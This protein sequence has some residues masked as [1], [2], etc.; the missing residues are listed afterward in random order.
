VEDSRA[1][2]QLN[3]L[4]QLDAE[5]ELQSCCAS[6]AWASRVAAARPFSDIDG[7]ISTSEAT[8]AGLDW[9]EIEAALS[10][11]PRIGQRAAGA[12]REASW[13]AQEQAS[14]AAAPVETS[15]ALREVNEAYEQRFG[16]V[17][18][19]YATGRSAEEMLAAARERLDHDEETERRVVRG[20]L[21]KIT[22]LRLRKLLEA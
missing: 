10:A 12:G 22:R 8:L 11:H 17:F 15:A 20:E 13:S 16:H 21:S 2:I 18:L 4:P 7:L 14:T 3:S 5:R 6:P 19:I 9:T 1:L